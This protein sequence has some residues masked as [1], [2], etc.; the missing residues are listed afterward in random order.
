MFLLSIV[1]YAAKLQLGGKSYAPTEDHAFFNFSKELV[2]FSN[3][4]NK[5]HDKLEDEPIGEKALTK[6]LNSLKSHLMKTLRQSSV[7]TVID[8]FLQ[9][10]KISLHRWTNVQVPGEDGKILPYNIFTVLVTSVLTRPFD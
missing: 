6:V 5:L 7:E 4:M 3:F 10:F 2:D 9:T 1:S 8:E